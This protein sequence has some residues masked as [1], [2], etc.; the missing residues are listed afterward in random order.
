[1]F[2]TNSFPSLSILVADS[3]LI[4]FHFHLFLAYFNTDFR[5]VAGT[6]TLPKMFHIGVVQAVRQIEN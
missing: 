2:P 3:R 5:I 1:M 4:G 6:G